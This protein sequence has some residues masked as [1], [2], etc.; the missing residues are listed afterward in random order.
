V[1]ADSGARLKQDQGSGGVKIQIV[2]V[3]R[4]KDGPERAL[5]GRYAERLQGLVRAA[6]FGPLSVVELNESRAS[7]AEARRLAEA[8]QLLART[9][10]EGRI[11]AL[12][13]RGETMTSP[14]FARRLESWRD[15]GA[16]C[17]GFLIGG[18][19][20][21][22]REALER[23]GLVLSLG[24]MTFPHGLARV[25]L[26]EQLYRAATLSANHPY[27]RA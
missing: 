16:P 17:V 10:G 7:S 24:P 11:V 5:F 12:D 22:G 18:P 1:S 26:M 27:H 19:D 4:L 13:E 6:S 9:P 21:H 8:R 15:N 25:V 2:A 14:A 3:G 20:G 23:A